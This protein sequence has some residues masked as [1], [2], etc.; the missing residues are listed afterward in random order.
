[1]KAKMHM[2]LSRSFKIGCASMV[3]VTEPT[4]LE[5]YDSKRSN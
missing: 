1:M 4:R 3:R 2:V 5:V